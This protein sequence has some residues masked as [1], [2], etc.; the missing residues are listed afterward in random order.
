MIRIRDTFD[1]LEIIFMNII[2]NLKLILFCGKRGKSIYYE[3]NSFKFY[4]KIE[5][6]C[7]NKATI[8]G[9]RD[10]IFRYNA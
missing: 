4:Y 2:N 7:V 5:I 3:Y 8:F 9:D 6:L 1:I 10:W